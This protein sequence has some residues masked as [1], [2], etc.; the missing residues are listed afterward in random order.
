MDFIQLEATVPL[1]FTAHL[2]IVSCAVSIAHDT[3]DGQNPAPLILHPLPRRGRWTSR[4]RR[5][6][7]AEPAAAAAARP[8]NQS[9]AAAEFSFGA[10]LITG[11]SFTN[12]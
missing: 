6:A 4:G 5:A 8:R 2:S 3:V 9:A 10:K 1:V 7:A 12:S 11:V